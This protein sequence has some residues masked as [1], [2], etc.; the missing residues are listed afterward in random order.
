MVSFA[1]CA[2]PTGKTSVITL[3]FPSGSINTGMGECGVSIADNIYSAFANPASLPA[4][5]E[6]NVAQFIYSDFREDLLPVYQIPNLYHKSHYSAALLNDALPHFDIGYTHSNNY[7]NFGVNTWTDESGRELGSANSYEE[8]SSNSIGLRAFKIASIGVSV[9]PFTSALAPGYGIHGEGTAKGSVFDVGLRLEYKRKLWNMVTVHPAIGLTF[10]NYGQKSVFYITEAESSPLP[11]TR[12]YGGS[13]QADLINLIGFTFA[14]ER[15]Y[16]VI[17]KEKIEHIGIKID[18]TPFFSIVK[19]HLTDPAGE[20]NQGMDGY[21]VTLNFYKTLECIQGIYN[22]IK[23]TPDN[24][25]IVGISEPM[26]WLKVNFSTRLQPTPLKP[27]QMI[28]DRD[29]DRREMILRLA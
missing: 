26:K 13:L 23:A 2:F 25:T 12:L 14:K 10:L 22:L 28:M 1:V 6:N 4:I 21:A 11:R 8:V 27:I 15:E 18:I 20:R 9:K 5:G 19:G 29:L 17:D 7:V 16:A 3:T 24:K